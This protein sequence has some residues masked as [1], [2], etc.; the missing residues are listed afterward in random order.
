MLEKPPVDKADESAAEHRGRHRPLD[1]PIVPARSP[2]GGGGVLRVAALALG[3]LGF[4]LW[5][6]WSATKARDAPGPADGAAPLASAHTI[7]TATGAP[8][9]ETRLTRTGED[10]MVRRGVLGSGGEELIWEDREGIWRQARTGGPRTRV[11][12]PADVPAESRHLWDV[13]ADGQRLVLGAHFVLAPLVVIDLQAKSVRVVREA[14]FGGILSHDERAI[15]YADAQG[16]AWVGDDGSDERRVASAG[17]G[18]VIHSFAWSPDDRFLAYRTKRLSSAAVGETVHTV[19]RDGQQHQ[20]IAEGPRL[21]LTHLGTVA[22]PEAE[23]IVYVQAGL[24]GARDSELWAQEVRD[25]VPTGAAPERLYIWPDRVVSQLSA[26]EGRLSFVRHA[27]RLDVL[28]LPLTG[29]PSAS[30]ELRRLTEDEHDDRSPAWTGAGEVLF[31]SNRRGTWDIFGQGPGERTAR[32]IVGG[33][34]WQT[35]P[36]SDG[37]GGVL[38]FQ[39]SVDEDGRVSDGELMGLGADGGVPAAIGPLPVEPAVGMH[40]RPPP[41]SHQVR[42]TRGDTPTCMIGTFAEGRLRFEELAP[43][44]GERGGRRAEIAPPGGSV[45]DWALSP[46]ADRIAVVGPSSE[47]VLVSLGDG[48][49]TS[50]AI[51]AKPASPTGVGWARDGRELYVTGH[52]LGSAPYGVARVSLDGETEPVHASDSTWLGHPVVSP[53]GRWLALT[54]M[55][56]SADVWMLEGL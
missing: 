50:M 48:S 4:A 3:G 36:R 21:S 27:E 5:A 32:F 23:R 9:R 35:W 16:L 38:F 45:V 43:G 53:D 7:W 18:D 34:G 13:Y 40:G 20:R 41:W 19:T 2:R 44:T 31:M 42:C 10:D 6:A 11:A 49:W 8:P 47:I 25:G 15:A 33:P 39:L 55:D 29:A 12:L 24:A 28:L 46:G 22:W 26:Q 1:E 52:P 14:A 30:P 37:A 17:Q 54:G 56:Q 51:R